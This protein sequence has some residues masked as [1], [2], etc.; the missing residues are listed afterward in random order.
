MA[1]NWERYLE[2]WAK[3]GL[4]EAPTA[5]RVR[6]YE[7]DQDK[8]R[9]LRWPIVIAIAFGGLLLA[10]GILL[11]VAAHWDKLSPAQRFAIVL[12]LVGVLHVAGAIAATRFDVLS[13]ALHAVGTICLGAGIFL[14]GQIFHLQ[15]HWPGGVMLWAMGAWVA[16]ALLRDWPQAA[17]AAILTPA[18]IGGEWSEATRRWVGSDTILYAG[19]LLLA[20]TYLT[21]RLQ[22]QATPVRKT[23]VW[24]GGLTLVPAAALVIESGVFGYGRSLPLPLDYYLLGWAAALLPPLA[25]AWWLRK[26]HVWINVIAAFWVAALSVTRFRFWVG[27]SDPFKL[28][29][30]LAMYA[31]CAL[32]AIGLIAWGMREGRKERVNLGIAGFALTV[33]FF[34]FST[35]MDKM[36]RSASLVGL[37]LLFL[38]GGWLLEKTRRRLLA[39]M[40]KEAV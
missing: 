10:A 22:A 28:A 31:L 29:D 40:G 36:G 14:T 26:K 19:L 38:L 24:I 3:A 6:A 13:T 1:A 9:G 34:Y 17:L 4:I 23:L 7:R 25:L 32:G 37:G 35:V 5:E 30:D 11:F 2:R 21:A 16:W 27:E 12:A 8:A 20:I 33:L 15:E 18:W 39:Q